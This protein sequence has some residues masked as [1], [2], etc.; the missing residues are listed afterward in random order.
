MRQPVLTILHQ[1]QLHGFTVSSLGGSC[2]AL[3]Q[4]LPPQ[5]RHVALN[6]LLPTEVCSGQVSWSLLTPW[7]QDVREQL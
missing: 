6:H 1:H 4:R 3:V 7:V 5:T 2:D